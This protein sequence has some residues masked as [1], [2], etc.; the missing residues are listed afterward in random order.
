M[1]SLL[2]KPAEEHFMPSTH[3]P[4]DKKETAL[5]KWLWIPLHL[6]V[7]ACAIHFQNVAL[8]LQLVTHMSPLSDRH[9]EHVKLQ[10]LTVKLVTVKFPH[11]TV[12]LS[13]GAWQSSCSHSPEPD[14]CFGAA[15]RYLDLIERPADAAVLPSFSTRFTNDFSPWKMVADT[16]PHGRRSSTITLE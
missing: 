10:S 14:V 1:S 5:F 4:T 15:R 8:V 3:T 11:D 13:G 9:V 6:A 2:N 16:I 12:V 7:G